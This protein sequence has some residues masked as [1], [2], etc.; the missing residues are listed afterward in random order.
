MAKVKKQNR[1]L[2]VAD[3]AV[4]GYLKRGYDQVDDSGKVVQRA[5]G[6]R[7]VPLSEYNKALDE[8]ESLKAQ[9]AEAA[10][11]PAAKKSAKKE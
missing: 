1:V 11:K 2:E 9:L 6:G 4:P 10:E 5:T 8:I 3:A 7:M